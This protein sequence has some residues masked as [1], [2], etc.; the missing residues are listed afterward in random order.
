MNDKKLLSAVRGG[1]ARPLE[2]LIDKYSPY[3]VAVIRNAAKGAAV[4]RDIEE[5][6]ADVF[7]ALWQSAES[8]NPDTL[9][10]YLAAIAR[11]KTVDRLRRTHETLPLEEDAVPDGQSF[12]LALEDEEQREGVREGVLMLPE[13]YRETLLLFY[14]SEQSAAAIAQRMDCT[15]NTVKQ[16]LHRGRK[17]LK[18]QLTRGSE[19]NKTEAE[20]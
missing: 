13:P 11:N 16:R 15:E 7:F 2:L 14:Y 20:K 8:V 10:A 3:V 4:P 1:D 17:M 19:Q 18:E 9:K 5:I 6:A 12:P